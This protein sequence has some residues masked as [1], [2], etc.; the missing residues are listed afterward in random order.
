LV[1]EMRRYV[2][3]DPNEPK[4]LLGPME[5][6]HSRDQIATQVRQSVKSGAKIVLGGEVPERTG[7]WYPATVL[8]NVQPGQPAHDEEVFGP[9][10]A[11][12]SAREEADAIRIANASIL[13]SG[14]RSLPATPLE[15]NGSLRKSWKPALRLSTRMSA[16]TH[17][18]HLAGSR[19]W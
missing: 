7:A 3:G 11:V 10:A 14:R 16:R 17:A 15:E 2:M 18:C 12:I 13:G 4:T 1:E 19:N 8:T 5:S 9:V 6:V